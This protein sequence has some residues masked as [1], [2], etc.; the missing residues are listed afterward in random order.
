ML[1]VTAI[2][3]GPIEQQVCLLA[4]SLRMA[5]GSLAASKML[6]LI[7][8]LGPSLSID[9]I[10]TCRRLNIEIA[11]IP[12][13]DKLS[14][15]SFL[16]KTQA[17]RFASKRFKGKIAWIDADVLFLGEPDRLGSFTH[18]AA[19]PSDKNIGTASDDDVYAPYFRRCCEILGIDFSSLPFVET[20][21]DHQRIRSYWNAGIFA[22]D[23]STG[24]AETYHQFTKVLIEK[25][26]GSPHCGLLMSDQVALG[27]A[28]H[29]LKLD[30][31]Q[32]PLSHNHH[33]QPQTATT[34]LSSSN[35]IRLLHYHGCLWPASFEDTVT[36]ISSRNSAIGDLVRRYGPLT[37]P[38]L[39]TKVGRRLLHLYRERIYRSADREAY[40]KLARDSY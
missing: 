27:L 26:V 1:L 5:G 19:S 34:E 24:L 40:N 22:F 12:R 25:R 16:N 9:T 6:A 37:S 23:S 14:W 32:L 31:S 39:R 4:E 8:R 33:I 30:I 36:G 7:P 38:S 20:V 15:F 10:R 3:A 29:K 18:F 2:E 35:T 17:V 21:Q 11:R 13:D 28:A